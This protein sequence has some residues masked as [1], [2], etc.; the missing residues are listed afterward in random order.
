[1]NV[2]PDTNE[3]L[4]KD[5]PVVSLVEALP[6]VDERGRQ[7]VDAWRAAQTNAE[8]SDALRA[9]VFCVEHH[10]H[11]PAIELARHSAAFAQLD[12]TP[13]LIAR[14]ELMYA[15]PLPLG[16]RFAI[17]TRFRTSKQSP[18]GPTFGC[19]SATKWGRVATTR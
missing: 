3:A 9:L 17:T 19:T 7:A 12:G 11:E 15:F 6:V 1:M 13:A 18:T 16:I 14:A 10:S 2:V 5:D 8:R 4:D